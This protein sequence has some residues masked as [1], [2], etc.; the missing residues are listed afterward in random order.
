MLQVKGSLGILRRL[1]KG[2]KEIG[3]KFISMN[4]E[5]LSEEEVVRITNEEFV[6]IR[7]DD[8][9]GKMDITLN[10]STPESDEQ[11]AKELAFMLQ[12]TGQTMGSEFSSLILSDIARLRKM[13]DLA[14]K[15]ANF[16]PQ[17]DPLAQEKAQLEIELLKAQIAKTQSDAQ[18]NQAN[19]QLDLAKTNTENAKAR[20]LG[21][22]SDIKDLNFLEQEKGIK[23]NR[24]KDKIN[25]QGE[26]NNQININKEASKAS[27]DSKNTTS[28]NGIS[29][30]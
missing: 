19:A 15:I 23:H 6:T 14:K 20:N 4:S 8:L 27:N 25:L 28:F 18:N 21:S 30:V 1:S 10:I 3:R 17:P 9:A 5:F 13:P 2:I 12:T 26:V 11:K 7:R 29:S 24:E 16:K 22:D